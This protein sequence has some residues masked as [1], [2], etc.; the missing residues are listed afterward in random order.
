MDWLTIG[1]AD[2]LTCHASLDLDQ[3]Y[4]LAGRLG[5]GYLV[6]RYDDGET[7]DYF[8]V[9]VSDLL[10]P[11]RTSP[12]GITIGDLVRRVVEPAVVIST[13]DGW[14]ESDVAPALGDAADVV[15][16]GGGGSISNVIPSAAVGPVGEAFTVGPHQ[17][18]VHLTNPM[19]AAGDLESLALEVRFPDAVRLGDIVPVLILL[20]PGPGGQN[21][22]PILA[23]DGDVIEVMVT[24]TSGFTLV[25][26]PSKNMTVVRDGG[27]LPVKFDL[28][29]DVLGRG[30]VK[31][32]AFRDGVCVASIAISADI[33]AVGA[34][35]DAASRTELRVTEPTVPALGDLDLFVVR[36]SFEGRPALRYRLKS[37]DG[38]IWRDFEAHSLDLEPDS[39]LARKFQEIQELRNEAGRWPSANSARFEQIGA[40]LYE[41]LVPAELQQ[42]LWDTDRVRSMVIQTDEPWI[43]WE[44]CR[45]TLTRDGVTQARGFLCD[46]FELTRWP[47]GVEPKTELRATRVGLIAP[48]DSGLATA[49]AE[50]EMLEALQ[51]PT[52]ERVKATYLD[53]L[54]V[55][56]EPRYD[57]LHF[58]GHGH[59][60]V[61]GDASETVFQL[62]GQW[63]LRPTDISGEARNFGAKAPIVFM[64][65]CQLVRGSM[66]LHGVG[67]WASVVTDA[68]AGAFVGSHWDVT[69]TL[70]KAFATTFYAE[71]EKSSTVAGAVR[72]ARRAV[73]EASRATRR[74]LPTPC[75]RIPTRSARSRAR[76]IGGET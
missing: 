70:A 15:V 65:A 75:T 3:A 47:P 76:E 36:E 18:H 59:S 58:I 63:R 50:A 8:V 41:E 68:G 19:A 52:V 4:E 49:T 39:Y 43:P 66:A 61:A 22:A 30:E 60:V 1:T 71:L 31:V 32:F 69:D 55:L 25:D 67:G 33:A 46:V 26:R 17:R 6:V 29:A 28:K 12:A 57:V 5:T 62:S 24:P 37:A 45:M 13:D 35:P 56:K 42:L 34:P 11:S 74:G 7:S 9:G 16:L 21:S 20:E 23:R 64:N 51:G 10:A 38:R 54:S 72:T 73:R 2:F 40:S 44:L 14:M 27:T 48:R 53:V